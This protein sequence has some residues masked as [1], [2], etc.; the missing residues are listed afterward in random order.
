MSDRELENLK[1][2]I[3]QSVLAAK[4]EGVS[5]EEFFRVQNQQSLVHARTVNGRVMA[6]GWGVV[7]WFEESPN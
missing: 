4:R 6:L 1:K 5:F 7:M 2:L 3:R